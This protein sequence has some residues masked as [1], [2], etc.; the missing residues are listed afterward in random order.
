MENWEKAKAADVDNQQKEIQRL[1]QYNMDLYNKRMEAAAAE[2]QARA[3][4]SSGKK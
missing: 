3:T 4:A 1:N 2:R